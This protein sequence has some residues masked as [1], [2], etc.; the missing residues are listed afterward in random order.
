MIKNEI[1]LYKDGSRTIIGSE[2]HKL[3]FSDV[4][5]TW[6]GINADKDDSLYGKYYV[7]EGQICRAAQSSLRGAVSYMTPDRVLVYNHEQD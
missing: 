2:A 3:A 1:I 7:Y 5:P 4:C 6:D